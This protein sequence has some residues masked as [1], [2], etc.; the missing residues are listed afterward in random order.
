MANYTKE[1]F[2]I[3]PNPT[4]DQLTIEY[5]SNENYEIYLYSNLGNKISVPVSNEI[6][7]TVLHTVGLQQG[8]YFLFIYQNNELKKK[9]IISI[10]K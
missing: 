7:K 4:I 6:G 1:V 5:E 8:I 10:I 3:Y 9:E 2:N